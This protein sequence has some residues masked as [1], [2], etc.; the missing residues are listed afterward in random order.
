MILI[1]NF[2][3]FFCSQFWNSFFQI[4]SAVEPGDVIGSRV[5]LVSWPTGGW[6]WTAKEDAQVGGQVKAPRGTDGIAQAL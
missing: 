1:F 6:W 2:L 5:Q 4:R 3:I